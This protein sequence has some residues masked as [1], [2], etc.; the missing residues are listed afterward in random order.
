MDAGSGGSASFVLADAGALPTASGSFDVVL[1]TGTLGL[2]GRDA[3]R[4]A[5]GDWRGCATGR[6]GS[7]E[8]VEGP[9][10]VA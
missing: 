4:V 10:G 3:Q 8:P 1:C 9:G 7:L 2:L 6:C 5:L